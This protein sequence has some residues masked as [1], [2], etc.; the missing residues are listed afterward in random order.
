MVSFLF[1]FRILKNYLAQITNLDEQK[2]AYDFCY[3]NKT[4]PVIKM[5]GDTTNMT[6]ETPVQMRVKYTSPNTFI[7]MWEKS[8]LYKNVSF[9]KFYFNRILKAKIKDNIKNG[10]V[11]DAPLRYHSDGR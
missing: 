10:V 6:L 2:K 11:C 9:Y 5:T 1:P 8:K 3:N 4:T 7:P